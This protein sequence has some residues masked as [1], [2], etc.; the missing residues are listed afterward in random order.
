MKGVDYMDTNTTLLEEDV[1]ATQESTSEFKTDNELK[2]AIEE[3]LSKIRTQ[4]MLLG[5][6]SMCQV[7]IN[8]IYAFEASS[9]KKSA[10]D[11]KRLIKDVKKFCETGLS[12]TV[13][14]DG[15]TEPID[16][17]EPVEETTQN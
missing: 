15:T 4:S 9:S 17:T 2:G 16:A 1:T 3:T 6:Q 11:Y 8:K 7:I 5:A 10:N 13:N 14:I 12:R